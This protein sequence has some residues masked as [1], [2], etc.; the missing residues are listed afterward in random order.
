VGPKD[1]LEKPRG[2]FTLSPQDLTVF[3]TRLLVVTTSTELPRLSRYTVNGV[4]MFVKFQSGADGPLAH[5][6]NMSG[7]TV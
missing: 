7:R 2:R 1:D 5:T 4:S 3:Q 6:T